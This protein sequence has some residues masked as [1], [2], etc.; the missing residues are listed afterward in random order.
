MTQQTSIATLR[1][2]SFTAWSVSL[3]LILFGVLSLLLYFRPTV[4]G[5]EP[6][7]TSIYEGNLTWLVLGALFVVSGMIF[8]SIAYRWPR[9]L[10]QVLSTQPAKPMRLKVEVEEDSD[11]TQYY[12]NLTDSAADGDPKGWRVSLWAPSADMQKLVGREL[13]T[14]VYLD[15]RTAEPAVIEYVD[16]YLWAMKGAVTASPASPFTR[17]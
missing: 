17:S 4:I 13:S 7:S 12:A 8:L 5:V 16:G 3:L 6:G 2:Y 10:L 14:K 9:H 1:R 11:H 15:P